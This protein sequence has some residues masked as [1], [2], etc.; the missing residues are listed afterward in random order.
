MCH[1]ASQSAF[2]HTQLYYLRILIISYLATFLGT[3]SLSVL[4]CHKAVNQS[5]N[6]INQSINQSTSFRLTCRTLPSLTSRPLVP[7]PL[8]I[9]PP[10]LDLNP[11]S[12]PTPPL[13]L[14]EGPGNPGNF[15]RTL[16][17]H[18]SQASFLVG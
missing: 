15:G 4:M 9:F 10:S 13:P 17:V 6:P 11:F 2:L 12:L 1:E 14:S 16:H 7:L 3:N 8:S 5:I 18:C